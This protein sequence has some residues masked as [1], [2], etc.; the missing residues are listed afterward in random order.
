[1]ESKWRIVL[2]LHTII[3]MRKTS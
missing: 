2:P 3:L 1:M